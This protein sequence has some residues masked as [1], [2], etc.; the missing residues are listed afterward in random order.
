M[1]R[2]RQQ[3]VN[4]GE[5]ARGARLVTERRLRLAPQQYL[6]V[7]APRRTLRQPVPFGG[8]MNRREVLGILGR[9]AVVPMLAPLSPE[10][11][12]AFGRA[13]HARLG[14]GRDLRTLDAHQNATVTRIAELI[15]PE[16]DTPGATTVKVNEFIDLLLTEWY[17]AEDRDRLLAG[18]ADIDVRSRQAY[19]APFV[20]VSADQQTALLT[21]LDG[22]RGD[23]GRRRREAGEPSEA[24][25]ERAF[26]R[27]KALTIYGYF[28]S[29]IVVRD[30][31]HHKVIPGRD[32]GCVPV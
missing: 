31:L 29:E 10:S 28:T 18:L 21:S 24:T 25:A 23:G 20:E 6:N 1:R 16:T 15:L 17:S 9:A 4:K 11:R 7:V 19:G 27:L 2:G 8:A 32:D 3:G 12:L 5:E 13:L 22:E 30:V 26:A 14:A